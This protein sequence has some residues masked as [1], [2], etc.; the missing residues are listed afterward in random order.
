MED[1][2][3][4]ELELDMEEQ[5]LAIEQPILKPEKQPS[6][7]VHPIPQTTTVSKGLSKFEIFLISAIAFIAFGLILLNIQSSLSLSNASRE[8]Q[9]VN[10]EIAQVE[11]EIENLKQQSHEL[12]QY[13]RINKIAQKHGLEL[14]EENII[15]IAPQE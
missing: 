3:A 2:L 15:N 12:S 8:V 4:R 5:A 6:P 7:R 9:D 11:I 13:D 1:N 10:H 14:H